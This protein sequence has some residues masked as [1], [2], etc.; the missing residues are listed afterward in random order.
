MKY[1]EREKYRK[2]HWNKLFISI[3]T[4]IGVVVLC[5][6]LKYCHS[7]K[8][9]IN[10]NVTISTAPLVISTNI[11]WCD[12]ICKVVLDEIELRSVV[13][14]DNYKTKISPEGLIM[15]SEKDTLIV[16]SLSYMKLRENI[17]VPQNRID[18][19]Y[20]SE[21]IQGLLSAYFDEMWFTP[22]CNDDN[23]LSL[24]EQRYVIYILLQHD[25]S[26]IIDC[27]SGCLYITKNTSLR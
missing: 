21:G 27:E 13:K 3:I 8:E 25:F 10:S 18:S 26:A 7:E 15:L 6:Y 1:M 22:Y 19:I 5:L 9:M 24:S 17:V 14:E 20:Q 16:D 11:K 23:I 4:I 12:S 2:N